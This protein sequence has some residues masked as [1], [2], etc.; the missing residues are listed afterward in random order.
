MKIIL[1][2]KAPNAV[3]ARSYTE[4]AILLKNKNSKN[5][6]KFRSEDN[7]VGSLKLLLKLL[8]FL[9]FLSLYYIGHLN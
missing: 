6:T 5:L 3:K 9:Y 4:R 7:F 1:C 2:K 8:G